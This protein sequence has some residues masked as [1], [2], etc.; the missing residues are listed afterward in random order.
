MIR[1]N[2]S[3]CSTVLEFFSVSSLFKLKDCEPALKF[4]LMYLAVICFF[5]LTLDKVFTV[6]H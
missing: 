6:H 4:A 1:V 2:Q 3:I 5:I